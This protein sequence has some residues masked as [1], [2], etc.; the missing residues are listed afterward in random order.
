MVRE[1]K[2]YSFWFDGLYMS[3]PPA[4]VTSFAIVMLRTRWTVPLANENYRLSD[5]A[6]A[7][8]LQTNK[9]ENKP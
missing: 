5:A 2:D 8:W 1:N 7:W 4:Y 9:E 3:N 6:G